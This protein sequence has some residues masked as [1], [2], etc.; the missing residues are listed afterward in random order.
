[1][2]AIQSILHPA[3]EGA[4]RIA[5]LWWIL[6]GVGMLVYVTVLAL[7]AWGLLRSRRGETAPRDDRAGLWLGVGGLLVPVTVLGGVLA[8]TLGALAA[9]AAADARAGDVRIKVVAKQ[10]WWE[11]EYHDSVPARR[12]HT[13]NELHVPVGRAVRLELEARDVI[14]SFWVPRLQAKRDMIPGRKHVFWLR[15]DSAGVYRGQCAEFCGMQHAKMAFVVVAHPP[16]EYAAWYE[17]ELRPA[18]EP[19]DTL[20]REGRR[21]FLEKPCAMC[22][23]VRGTP[24][25]ARAGPDL[26]HLASRLTLAAGTL[27]MSRGDLGGWIANPQGIKPGS[28]MPNVELDARELRA[29]I[30]YL[31]SLR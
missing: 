31:A 8:L 30:A 4:A 7:A 9:D 18:P 28:H 25:M 5:R 17:R 20:A 23:T 15:A 2:D 10:W 3:G 24:A 1:M 27:K 26:T 19:T 14:H 29:L 16:A 21:V 13:A 11:I 12:L 22:H 6:F